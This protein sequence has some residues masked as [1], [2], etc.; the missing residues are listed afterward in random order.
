MTQEQ[1]KAIE[2]IKVLIEEFD[3]IKNLGITTDEIINLIQVVTKT[4]YSSIKQPDMDYWKPLITPNPPY[5]TEPFQINNTLQN[6]TKFSPDSINK[7]DWK[8]MEKKSNLDG[9]IL[10]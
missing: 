8:L 9:V 10:V 3:T 5:T 7:L 2:T 6:Q 4:Y 1:T